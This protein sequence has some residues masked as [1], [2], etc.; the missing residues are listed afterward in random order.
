MPL[1]YT[2]NN[3]ERIYHIE[4]DTITSKSIRLEENVQKF[5]KNDER[6]LSLD[7]INLTRIDSLSIALL[8]RFEKQLSEQNRIIKLLNTS[9]PVL[10]VLEMANIDDR[11]TIE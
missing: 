8:I 6:D 5:I 1:K 4:G 3:E 10:K 7:I 9:E 11:F 2:D